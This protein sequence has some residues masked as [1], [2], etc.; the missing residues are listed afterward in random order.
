MAVPPGDTVVEERAK[1]GWA[2]KRLLD[3][4][5]GPLRSMKLLK[6]V[7]I[8]IKLGGATKGGPCAGR[9]RLTVQDEQIKSE[10]C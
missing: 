4:H 3:K 10:M 2:C 5:T 7:L 9:T 8:F 6:R 1:V